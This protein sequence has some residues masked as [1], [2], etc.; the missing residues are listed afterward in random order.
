MS[1]VSDLN[2]KLKRWF[3]LEVYK[4]EGVNWLK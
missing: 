3:N 4:V 1:D 2:R